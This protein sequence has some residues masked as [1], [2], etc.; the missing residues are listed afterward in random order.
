M[1]DTLQI[2]FI[3][4][5][6]FLLAFLTSFLLD[7]NWV[8]AHWSR[9]ALVLFLMALQ[10]FVGGHVLYIKSKSMKGIR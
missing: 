4:G 1:K 8:D 2:I 7:F 3:I 5:F 6:T 9:V 10:L